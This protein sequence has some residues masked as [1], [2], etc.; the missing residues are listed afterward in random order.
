MV[1]KK[2]KSKDLVLTIGADA[3]AIPLST[4]RNNHNLTKVVVEAS[5]GFTFLNKCF[6]NCDNLAVFELKGALPPKINNANVYTNMSGS[7]DAA[8]RKVIIPHG[9]TTTYSAHANWTNW[10]TMI[11]A[12]G[13]TVVEAS[14]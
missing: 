14:E 7:V 4:F 10:E 1:R 5:E 8:N 13:F 6:A 3:V 12:L 11:D 9:A 2:G